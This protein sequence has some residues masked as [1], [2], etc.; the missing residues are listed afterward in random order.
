MPAGANQGNKMN[1]DWKAM[2]QQTQ[3]AITSYELAAESLQGVLLGHPYVVQVEGIPLAF[4]IE[5]G[6]VTKPST[7][8]PQLA[9][10][11]TLEDAA[12]VA[13]QVKNGNGTAGEVVHVRHAIASAIAGQRELL[14]LLE[15]HT[16]TTSDQQ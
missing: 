3:N 1:N 6:V 16:N 15:A 8:Q 13:A 12:I 9:T 11:F 7:S 10:R 4:E 14:A 5:N 2:L